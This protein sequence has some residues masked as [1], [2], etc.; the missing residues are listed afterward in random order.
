M[1]ITASSRQSVNNNS[2]IFLWAFEFPN[3]TPSGTITAHLPEGA[4][5][6]YINSKNNNSVFV[7]FILNLSLISA[8]F[9]L[10][11]NGGFA[12]ITSYLLSGILGSESD[13]VFDLYIFGFLIPC[14][15]KFIKAILVI[16][17]SK[18]NPSIDSS[19]KIFF[20]LGVKVLTPSFLF[21]CK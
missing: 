1:D 19:S 20:C 4:R 6:K 14:I 3:K 18:S 8:S 13:K 9:K 10:P 11:L 7:V 16:V 17:L 5:A 21:A 15:I 2:L 12:R